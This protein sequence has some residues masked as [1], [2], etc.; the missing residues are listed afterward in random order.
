[1]V[2]NTGLESDSLASHPDTPPS[3]IVTP[4]YEISLEV[5]CKMRV[6]KRPMFMV[7]W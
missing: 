1:M 4:R 7:L 2:A 5:I 6:T 3:Y